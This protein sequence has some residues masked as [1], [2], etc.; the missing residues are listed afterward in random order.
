[1]VT[2]Y[3][4]MGTYNRNVHKQVLIRV[5]TKLMLDEY[6]REHSLTSYNAAIKHLLTTWEIQT[7]QEADQEQQR[8]AQV[9]TPHR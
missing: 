7:E 9:P 8:Q 5:S 2:T 3:R 6:I 4:Y 1:M